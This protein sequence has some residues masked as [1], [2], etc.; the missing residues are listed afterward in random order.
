MAGITR[1]IDDLSVHL[2]TWEEGAHAGGGGGGPVAV[3]STALYST[4]A[5][6]VGW[7]GFCQ[8]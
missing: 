2:D 5:L 3:S 7:A 4:L 6:Q 1:C 8:F